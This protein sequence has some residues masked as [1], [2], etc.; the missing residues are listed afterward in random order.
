MLIQIAENPFSILDTQYSSTPD[1]IPSPYQDHTVRPPNPFLAEL[2]WHVAKKSYPKLED[3][4]PDAL[5]NP[6]AEETSSPL[7][8]RKC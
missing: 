4:D 7:I 5:P 6:K 2:E 3:I 1:P 8:L